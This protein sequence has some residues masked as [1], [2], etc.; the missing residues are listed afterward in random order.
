MKKAFIF[1]LDGTIVDSVGAIAACANDCLAEKGLKPQP[2]EAYKYFAGD[3]QYEL[4]KRA[5]RA[6]GDEELRCYDEVMAR[7]IELFKDRCHVGCM[8]Y[9]GVKETL[10]VLKDKGMFLA[11]LSNKAHANS[12]KVVEAVYGKGFFDYIQGQMDS[13]N[14]KPSPDGAF[15]VMEKLKVSREECV[16]VGDTSVDMKT[17]K[18]AG[19][20]TVGV[21]WGFRTRDEL[22]ENHADAVI[23]RPEELL[24]YIE[25]ARKD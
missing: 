1:D 20:F 16:Y 6:A 15:L 10:Q 3:G 7:Y 2:V 24:K 8:P 23:D 17:G 19:I 11:V 4:I 12:I 25:T 21:T 18:A 5:L 9:D 22:V 13:I 14:R